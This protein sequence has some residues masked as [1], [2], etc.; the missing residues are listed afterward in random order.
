[1]LLVAIVAPVKAERRIKSDG[2]VSHCRPKKDIDLSAG[3]GPCSERRASEER[4][5]TTLKKGAAAPRDL[6]PMA[7]ILATAHHCLLF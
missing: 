3:I 4:S 2:P 7:T 1:M 6:P 5:H